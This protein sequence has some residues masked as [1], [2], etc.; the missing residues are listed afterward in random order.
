LVTI[1]RVPSGL[2]AMALIGPLFTAISTTIGNPGAA[3]N[4]MTWPFP[5]AS[6]WFTSLI[7]APPLLYS[8]CVHGRDSGR[9]NVCATLAGPDQQDS[10]T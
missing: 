5:A 1:R 3:P 4:S 2:A 10:S 9:G 8:W 6:R 7:L